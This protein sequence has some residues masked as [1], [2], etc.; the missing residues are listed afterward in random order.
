[1]LFR[2][3]Y[4]IDFSKYQSKGGGVE[5]KSN[6]KNADFPNANMVANSLAAAHQTHKFKNGAKK[7]EKSFFIAFLLDQK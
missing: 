6:Y 7:F 4:E 1:L 3:A 5:K 2:I